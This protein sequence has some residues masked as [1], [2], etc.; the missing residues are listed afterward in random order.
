MATNRQCGGRDTLTKVDVEKIGDTLRDLKANEITDPLADTLGN[1]ETG[2][3]V[4]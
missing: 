4:E 3:L 2:T 1:A